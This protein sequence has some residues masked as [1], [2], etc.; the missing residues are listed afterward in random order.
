[1]FFEKFGKNWNRVHKNLRNMIFSYA[2]RWVFSE[3]VL[4]ELDV[5]TKMMNHHTNLFEYTPS[6]KF[7]PNCSARLYIV[8]KTIGK[9]FIWYSCTNTHPVHARFA[10]QYSKY[11]EREFWRIKNDCKKNRKR[12]TGLYRQFS[13]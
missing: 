11:G 3:C 2:H 12:Y 10:K 1:L 7:C 6:L 8:T 13:N 4:K 5:V 9:R